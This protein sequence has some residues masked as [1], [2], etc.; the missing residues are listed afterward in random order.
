M[1]F[2]VNRFVTLQN[3]KESKQQNSNAAPTDRQ[4]ICSPWYPHLDDLAQYQKQEF[5]LPINWPDHEKYNKKMK[6]KLGL[7]F[8]FLYFCIG[9]QGQKMIDPVTRNNS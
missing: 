6:A 3:V 8:L 4:A 9:K 5:S 7:S 2:H 1:E